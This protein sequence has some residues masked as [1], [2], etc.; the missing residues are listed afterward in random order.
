MT[1]HVHGRGQNWKDGL[2]A[3]HERRRWPTVDRLTGASDVRESRPSRERRIERADDTSD[4]CVWKVIRPS[5]RRKGLGAS[6]ATH[7]LPPSDIGIDIGSAM[8]SRQV[9]P[10]VCDGES[11]QMTHAASATGEPVR[12]RTIRRVVT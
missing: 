1:M 4:V 8:L 11:H 6:S 9:V 2:Q 3:Q 12:V 5:S 10:T 7:V